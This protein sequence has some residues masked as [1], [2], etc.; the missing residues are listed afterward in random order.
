MGLQNNRLF[1]KKGIKGK[2]EWANIQRKKRSVKR[3]R[4]FEKGKWKSRLKRMNGI[5]N[6]G[7]EKIKSWKR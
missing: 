1:R 6:R 7:K 5:F 3:K 4:M 2:D